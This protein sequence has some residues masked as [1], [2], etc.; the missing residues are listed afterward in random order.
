MQRLGLAL[1][2]AAV[3]SALRTDRYARVV[4][5]ISAALE[6]ET[7]AEAQEEASLR[8]LWVGQWGEVEQSL[9]RLRD[10]SDKICLAS[11]VKLA[12]SGPSLLQNSSALAHAVANASSKNATSLDARLKTLGVEGAPKEAMEALN[13]GK[14]GSANIMLGPTLEMLKG[15]YQ[16][17]REKI[18]ELNKQ[19]KESKERFAKKEKRHKEKLANIENEAKR[20]KWSEGFHANETNGENTMFKH[21]LRARSIQHSQYHNMLKLTHS[22]M[23]KE[24]RMID[25]YENTLKGGAAREKVEKQMHSAQQEVPEIVFFQAAESLREFCLQ[26]LPRVRAWRAELEHGE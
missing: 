10:L 16:Q 4:A 22:I 3:A 11:P 12:S 13:L 24:K 7:K 26:S 23:T 18:A 19:E 17:G 25:M 20:F 2:L 14:A 15:L 5:G 8:Q 9:E 21:Y 1:A 6:A